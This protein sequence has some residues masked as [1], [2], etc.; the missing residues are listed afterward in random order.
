MTTHRS[1][2]REGFRTDIINESNQEYWDESV[3]TILSYWFCV[4]AVGFQ[5]VIGIIHI[6]E[7]FGQMC[8]AEGLMGLSGL[9]LLDLLHG[10]KM[11]IKPKPF[12]KIHPNTFTRF[13]ITFGVIA[14]IQFLFQIVPLITREEMAL[15]IVFCSVCEE[16]FFRGMLLEL[17]FRMGE[18]SKDKFIIW[19]YKKE[20]KKPDKEMSY[21]ELGGIVLSATLF[22]SFHINYYSQPRL[23]LMVFVGGCWL[24]L[25]YWWN[26]DLTSVILSHF[27]LNIIFVIQFYQVTGL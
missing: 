9:L 8:V 4:L 6:D 19:R 21:I 2:G 13:V 7:F 1:Y 5:F 3:H 17:V 23:L 22:S 26:K 18:K 24:G 25:V 10:R 15:A 11:R 27:L 16:Y 12:K 14:L 20:K